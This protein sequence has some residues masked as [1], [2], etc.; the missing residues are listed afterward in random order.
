MPEEFTRART[1]RSILELFADR[2]AAEEAGDEEEEDDDDDEEEED[3]EEDEE[4]EEEG[5]EDEEE[6]EGTDPM[7]L[8]SDNTMPEILVPQGEIED[9]YFMHGE[10]LRDKY[11]EVELDSFMKLL[12]I[13][14]VPQWE[15][16]N[17]H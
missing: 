16:N 9:R 2:K 12:N 14:P 8:E 17:T 3:E 7:A 11:S 4:E 15:E 5:D 1:S 10:T 6:E 13:K